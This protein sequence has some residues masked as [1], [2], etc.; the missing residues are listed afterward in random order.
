MYVIAER[1]FSKV[2]LGVSFFFFLLSFTQFLK[3]TLEIINPRLRHNT[4]LSLVRGL[5]AELSHRQKER[6]RDRSAAPS[7]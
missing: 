4:S 7:W 2:Q 1:D 6:E 3:K 5:W